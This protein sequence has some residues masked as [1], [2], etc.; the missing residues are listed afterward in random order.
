MINNKLFFKVSD[1]YKMS[2][3]S[4]LLDDEVF[5]RNI[6]IISLQLLNKTDYIKRVEG[7]DLVLSR[8][9]VIISLY[10]SHQTNKLTN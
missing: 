3:A 9:L 4:G 6:D 7:F 2:E 8:Q 1:L 10:L 5:L